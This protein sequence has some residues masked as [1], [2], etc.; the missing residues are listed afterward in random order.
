M[1]NFLESDLT[2]LDKFK[3]DCFLINRHKTNTFLFNFTEHIN[4]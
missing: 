4:S 2:V 3:L 1:M